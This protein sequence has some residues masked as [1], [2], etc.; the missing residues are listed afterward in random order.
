MN[1]RTLL[2]TCAALTACIAAAPGARAAAVITGNATFNITTNDYTYIYSVMNTGTVEDLALVT[3]PVMSTLGISSVFA[4]TGF[5]LAYDP[6][7][8]WVNFIEDGS[9]ITPETFAPG[10][11]VGEF[12]FNSASMP[13]MVQYSA[14]DA[15]GT[16][17]NGSVVAPVPEPSGAL[18]TLL[19]GSTVLLRRRR[20]S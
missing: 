12:R 14:F 7:Q 20:Q 19:A 13:G 8:G 9:I 6:S 3:I 17:F 10:S 18:L 1:T 11:T 2:A 4:P 16:E 5:T 15:A